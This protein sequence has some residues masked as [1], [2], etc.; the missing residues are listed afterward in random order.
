MDD[1]KI[2]EERISLGSFFYLKMHQVFICNFNWEMMKTWLESEEF[3]LRRILLR[4]Q[5][6]PGQAQIS[7]LPIK[8]LIFPFLMELT[9]TQ[10]LNWSYFE[11]QSFRFLEKFA[12][13]FCKLRGCNGVMFFWSRRSIVW[14]IRAGSAAELTVDYWTSHLYL[15][16]I[17]YITSRW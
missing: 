3:Q 11:Y 2:K 7:G 15:A 13:F 1:V 14:T 5:S 6:G 16:Y 9:R 10:E 4:K 12:Y 8:V 17:L